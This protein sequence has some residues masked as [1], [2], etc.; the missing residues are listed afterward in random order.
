MNYNIVIVNHNF[1]LIHPVTSEVRKLL[2][3]EQR[4]YRK[5]L[6]WKTLVHPLIDVQGSFYTGLVPFV[7]LNFPG[8]EVDDQ[9]IWPDL[10]HGFQVPELT[11]D[12]RGYQIDY[13]F[14]ALKN[15][16]RIIESDTGSGKTLM[17]A[18]I[19]T[20]YDLPT[21][22]LVPNKTLLAQ[23]TTELSAL[24]PG[25]EFS[26]ASGDGV[27]LKRRTLG[28][29]S[30]L[31]KLSNQDLQQFKVLLCDECH[32]SAGTR[33]TDVILRCGAPYRFGFTGTSK[34]R[35]DNRDLVVQG[36]FGPPVKLV[37]T[38]KLT[39]AG[40]LAPVNIQVYRGWWEASYAHLEEHLIVRNDLRNRMIAELVSNQKG[41][42][43]I[44]VHRV[45]HGKILQEMIPGSIFVHGDTESDERERIRI[46]VQQGQYRVLI[47]SNVFALGLDIPNLEV[48]INAAGGKA[49]ILAKQRFGRITRPWNESVKKYIDVYDDYHPG[50][51]EHSKERIKYYKGK[52][53]HIQ[54][55]GFPPGKQKRLESDWDEQA[56]SDSTF[57][58]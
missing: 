50:L 5:N 49:E 11:K 41:A 55:I 36:L 32:T 53:K 29:P 57:L 28:L 42:I 46:A 40:Y 4:I 22:I 43:L 54:F 30:T 47:A 51:E 25:S 48:C 9:R 34:G 19:L 10:D 44:L 39:E 56:K 20:A 14:D 18:L 7:Q 45:E 23:L 12:P 26:Q 15:H 24:I 16:R 21:L 58:E 33:T 38:E 37:Q 27:V 1:A 17:M 6:G 35:S 8:T 52:S 2:Q 31:T 13:L 3:C